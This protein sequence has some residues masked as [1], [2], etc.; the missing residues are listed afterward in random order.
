MFTA[1]VYNSTPKTP[2]TEGSL[3]PTERTDLGSFGQIFYRPCSPGPG[4][5]ASAQGVDR[6]GQAGRAG[7][8]LVLRASDGSAKAENASLAQQECGHP[9]TG[10]AEACRPG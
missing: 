7:P 2:D 1:N 9:R 3:L 5:S 8:L 4:G 6:S 10:G